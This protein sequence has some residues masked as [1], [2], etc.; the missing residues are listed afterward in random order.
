MKKRF[1]TSLL[2]LSICVSFSGCR[3][4]SRAV[5]PDTD[6]TSDVTDSD[7][8]STDSDRSR[9]IDSDDIEKLQSSDKD[10][11]KSTD[12]DTDKNKTKVESA[13]SSIELSG[14]RINAETL[15]FDKEFTSK[16]SDAL[17]AAVFGNTLYILDGK[18][19]LSFTLSDT[20]AVYDKAVTL[21]Q[22]YERVDADVFG[23]IILS[24]EKFHAAR[25]NDDGTINELDHT[26]KTAL[27]RV[28]NFG[29]IS[30]GGDTVSVYS[31][32]DSIT[33]DALSKSSETPISPD[34]P[35]FKKIN[36]IEFSGSSILVGGEYDDGEN[37]LRAAIFDYDGNQTALTDN[38][39]SGEYII[40]MAQS[41]GILAVTTGSSL[42]LWSIDGTEIG[43]TKSS[44][45][46]KLFGT[47]DPL[48]INDLITLDD[49]SVLTLCTG[50]ADN[51]QSVLLYKMTLE[52]I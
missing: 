10:K 49:G 29:L 30:R 37:T 9:L 44:Q 42:S 45:T 3:T 19:I 12:E 18:R 28:L 26:G 41:N 34:K 11:N 51:K 7:R 2:V 23:N 47:G 50:K 15:P 38:K 22:S 32:D 48:W 4:A 14:I 35:K 24:S 5:R 17:D 13:P 31:E 1:L 27:S 21:G 8:R 20:E 39:I 25:L 43:Q 33:W 40:S 16:N 52:S 6:T 36:D 46:A